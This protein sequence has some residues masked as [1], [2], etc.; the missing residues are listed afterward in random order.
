MHSNFFVENSTT[1]PLITTKP[2][3]S[4]HWNFATWHVRAVRKGSGMARP[5]TRWS[6]SFLPSNRWRRQ[7][8]LQA[9][10]PWFNTVHFQWCGHNCNARRC[11]NCKHTPCFSLF[12][13][14]SRCFSLFSCCFLAVFTLQY[15]YRSLHC[16][17]YTA[18]TW[19]TWYATPPPPLCTFINWSA[20]AA[21]SGPVQL[22]P[23]QSDPVRSIPV[24]SGVG[25]CRAVQSSSD[26]SAI[27][28]DHRVGPPPARV[29]VW[30]I[31]PIFSARGTK[32]NTLPS[33][34]Q[35]YVCALF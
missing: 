16:I 4:A 30:F 35:H 34:W 23:A 2:F 8:F 9:Q 12:L 3:N 15:D 14:V 17:Q 32:C 27:R 19:F 33:A 1:L 13:A 26:R 7:L 31:P 6:P 11:A 5:S 20:S 10:K 22:S 28:Y 24:Q 29:V 25:R 18:Y 21:C